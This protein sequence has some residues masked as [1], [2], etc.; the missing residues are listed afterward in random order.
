MVSKTAGHFALWGV[1]IPCGTA[2][3][4]WNDFIF[5]YGDDYVSSVALL[6]VVGQPG[7]NECGPYT[8]V[9]VIACARALGGT[10]IKL[11]QFV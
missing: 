5:Y 8:S 1:C 11:E 6:G 3:Q 7:C 2:I 10:V 4:K 9:T